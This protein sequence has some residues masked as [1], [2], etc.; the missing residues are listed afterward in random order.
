MK[1]QTRGKFY[2]LFVYVDDILVIANDME[3]DRLQ[4]AFT[5]EFRWITVESWANRNW[6]KSA[7]GCW[8]KVIGF[9]RRT[10]GRSFGRSITRI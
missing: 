3:F 1:W 4:E 6:D 8:I 9:D 5:K 7:D 10:R 2:L